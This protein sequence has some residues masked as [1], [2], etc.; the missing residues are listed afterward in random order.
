MLRVLFGAEMA[1]ASPE[2]CPASFLSGSLS[3]ARAT[4]LRTIPLAAIS[5]FRAGRRTRSIAAAPANKRRDRRKLRAVR[6]KPVGLAQAPAGE[7]AAA[8]FACNDQR[9]LFRDARLEGAVDEA[10]RVKL[11]VAEVDLV[12]IGRNL[13]RREADCRWPKCG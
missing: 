7:F 6:L 4:L 12:D 11:V 13:P 1:A 5:L 2:F 8:R 10:H 9:I 3:G